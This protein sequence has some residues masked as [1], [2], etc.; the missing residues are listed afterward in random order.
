MLHKVYN[1]M[2]TLNI[3]INTLANFTGYKYLINFIIAQPIE[4][5]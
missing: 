5:L 3:N 2:R 4:V 1:I